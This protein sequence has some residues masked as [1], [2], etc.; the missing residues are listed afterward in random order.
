MSI[1]EDVRK[2]LTA[3]EDDIH[4]ANAEGPVVMEWYRTILKEFAERR[5]G[6]G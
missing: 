5:T 3:M 1:P 6:D 4:A 2:K